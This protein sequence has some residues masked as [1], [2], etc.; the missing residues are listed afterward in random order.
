MWHLPCLG[1]GGGEGT[2]TVISESSLC[3]GRQLK[4]L[5]T[6]FGLIFSTTHKVHLIIPSLRMRK[7]EAQR[8]LSRSYI[9]R[10][11]PGNVPSSYPRAEPSCISVEQPG[12]GGHA[13]MNV[14][15]PHHPA[16]GQSALGG[17]K[18]PS[19]LL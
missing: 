15:G 19:T 8:G 9:G 3:A 18:V 2:V 10:G 12:P 14:F 16:L 5:Q 17:H 13:G 1:G 6:H 7:M 4:D 11:K